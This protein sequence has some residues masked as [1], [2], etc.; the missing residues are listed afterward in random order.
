MDLSESESHSSFE[1]GDQLVVSGPLTGSSGS[2][3]KSAPF[4]GGCNDPEWPLRFL[5]LCR[6]SLRSVSNESANKTKL[7]WFNEKY[8]SEYSLI[9][10][11]SSTRVHMY[12]YS[13]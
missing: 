2:P 7:V 4:D 11:S 13:I 9:T 3:A 5:Q 12:P 10:A 1:I 8:E 6:A